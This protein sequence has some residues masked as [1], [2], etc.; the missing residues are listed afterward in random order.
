MVLRFYGSTVLRFYGSTVLWF[1]GSTVLWFYGSTVLWFYGRR[2]ARG[3]WGL[4]V[5]PTFYRHK[6]RHIGRHCIGKIQREKNAFRMSIFSQSGAFKCKEMECLPGLHPGT[7]QR[8]A[9]CFALFNKKSTP[10]LKI[11]ATPLYG[12]MVLRLFGSILFY[13]QASV[14]RTVQAVQL[15]FI[16]ICAKG[17]RRRSGSCLQ[18][19]N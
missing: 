1:Y 14:N 2:V 15:V 10:H 16:L 17:Q 5:R 18:L 6:S 19:I 12:S 8:L 11:L 9:P 4:W 7:H 3:G 13:I